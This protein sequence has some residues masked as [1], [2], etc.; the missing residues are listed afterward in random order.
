MRR[1]KCCELVRLVQ[2]YKNERLWDFSS[3]NHL[4]LP[5]IFGCS[6]RYTLDSPCIDI[7][8]VVAPSSSFDSCSSLRQKLVARHH[9]AYVM[10]FTRK[11]NE[12]P[13]IKV[14][15]RKHMCCG[16]LKCQEFNLQYFIL[17]YSISDTVDASFIQHFFFRSYSSDSISQFYGFL[18]TLLSAVCV[19]AYDVLL[20]GDTWYAYWMSEPETRPTY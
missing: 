5:P 10:H 20:C 18:L 12:K 8:L 14:V 4:L 3:R 15:T 19:H 7:E 17:Y 1:D 2:K 13:S 16:Q 9:R 11:L 6:L